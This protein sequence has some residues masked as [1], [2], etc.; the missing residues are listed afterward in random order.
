VNLTAQAEEDDVSQ[1]A[2]A[3]QAQAQLTVDL[4]ASQGEIMYG[5]NGALYGLSDDGVPGDAALEPLTR[6]ATPSP[7]PTPSSATAA[8][9]ST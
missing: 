4:G 7:S 8:A 5:A 1:P 3:A 9:T 6:T 2:A